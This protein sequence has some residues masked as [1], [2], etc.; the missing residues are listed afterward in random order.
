MLQRAANIKPIIIHI[1]IMYSPPP[2]HLHDTPLYSLNA[3]MIVDDSAPIAA[4]GEREREREREREGGRG[5]GGREREGGGVG[6][7][8]DELWVDT[9]LKITELT[10]MESPMAPTTLMS[11]GVNSLTVVQIIRPHKYYSMHTTI[12]QAN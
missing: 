10:V 12:M 2:T 5:G 1:I 7:G 11:A 3:V 4:Y 8:R 9:K 6:E